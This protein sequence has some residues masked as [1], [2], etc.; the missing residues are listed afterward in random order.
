MTTLT[1]NHSHV[2]ASTSRVELAR[3]LRGGW[4]LPTFVGR[5]VGV[6]K[7]PD[8]IANTGG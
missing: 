5:H 6:G 1:H 8:A 2:R 3:T 4:V 7:A